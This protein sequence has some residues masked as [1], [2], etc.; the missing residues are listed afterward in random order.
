MLSLA[1]CLALAAGPNVDA[2]E[3]YFQQGRA[4]A[5]AGDF[6]G[7]A[8]LFE[9]S[10]EAD[11]ALGTLLNW[12]ENAAKAGQVAAPF[13]LYSTALQVAEK[14]RRV[15]MPS[16]RR[17]LNEE[18]ISIIKRALAAL[19]PKQR[20]VEVEAYSPELEVDVQGE[21]VDVL[22][23]ATVPVEAGPVEVVVRLP[24]FR[25]WRAAFDAPQPGSTLRVVVP[26]LEREVDLAAGDAPRADAPPPAHKLEA[27]KEEPSLDELGLKDQPAPQASGRTWAGGVML[28]TGLVALVGGAMALGVSLDVYGRAQRQRP[29]GP[30]E[31]KPTVSL[32]EFQTLAWS[33]PLGWS[34]LGLGAAL[35]ATGALLLAL[36]GPRA[37]APADSAGGAP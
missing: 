12:A 4:K 7:A 29:G 14:N 31:L 3:R 17:Q 33:Y 27:P 8:A 21:R 11:P 16:E 9:L 5:E 22:K 19:T 20:W 37:A 30:D 36:P 10:Y 23:Q 24:K 15:A 34:A 32:A 6:K 2:A 13:R 1:L 26:K 28:V 18:R 35:S 25:P